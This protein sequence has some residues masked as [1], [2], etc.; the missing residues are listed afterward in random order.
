MIRSKLRKLKKIK[1]RLANR[2]QTLE[3]DGTIFPKSRQSNYQE[4]EEKTLP[5]KQKKIDD[6]GVSPYYKGRENIIAPINEEEGDL[7]FEDAYDDEWGN[8]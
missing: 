1:G 5:I 2:D 8:N 6:Q 7:E 3:T 4:E